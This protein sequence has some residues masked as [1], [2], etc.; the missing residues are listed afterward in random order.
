MSIILIKKMLNIPRKILFFLN[1]QYLSFKGSDKKIINKQNQKFEQLGLN[2]T[3]ALEKIDETCRK[4]LSTNFDE[5]NGMFS[6]H[7]VLLSA[8][9]LKRKTVT[10]ILEIGTFDGI[11]STLISNLFP[12]AKIVTIDLPK[13]D[14][15]FKNTYERSKNVNDFIKRRKFNLLNSPNVT[16]KEMNSILL[17]KQIKNEYDLI[18]IDGAHGYPIITIDI[19]NSL[20]LLKKGGL[21]LIDDVYVNISKNDRMY[22][23][24][25]AFETLKELKKASLISNYF[26]FNKRIGLKFN[27]K[28]KTEKFVGL[29]ES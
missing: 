13:S 15:D 2:R 12:N 11:A 10:N 28:G 3:K 1:V 21:I 7:L 29:I 5:N 25:A 6:E 19:I 20:R 18:W 9:S 8:I 4:I 26:L 16:F 17:C 27:I 14:E 23:S 24:V 22:E